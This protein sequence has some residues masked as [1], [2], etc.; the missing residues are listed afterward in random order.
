MSCRIG[1]DS[2]KSTDPDRCPS[3]AA[4]LAISQAGTCDHCGSLVTSGDFDWILSS[5]EQ[6]E[7]YG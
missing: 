6:D 3:C 4:S 7:V 2:S 1:F 5:I